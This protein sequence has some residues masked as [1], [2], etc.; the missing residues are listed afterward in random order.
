MGVSKV[1]VHWSLEQ[2]QGDALSSPNISLLESMVPPTPSCPTS[3]WAADIQSTTPAELVLW[4]LEG[5]V[6]ARVPAFVGAG[7][8]RY[9]DGYVKFALYSDTCGG[10]LRLDQPD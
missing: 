2:L 1:R 10:T 6:V 9:I 5:T 7:T 3:P 8:E 4:S